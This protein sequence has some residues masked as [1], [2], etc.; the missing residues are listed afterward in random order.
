VS[1]VVKMPLVLESVLYLVTMEE[2]NEKY[3]TSLSA[4][5]A[6]AHLRL[7]HILKAESIVR[8]IA[9]TNIEEAGW[10]Q[11][12]LCIT[13]QMFHVRFVVKWF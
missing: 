1:V 4:N 10:E 7:C 2:A 6:N 8:Q 5:F 13:D 3:I 12:I 11:I 9:G